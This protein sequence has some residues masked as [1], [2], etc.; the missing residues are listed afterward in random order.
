MKEIN[1]EEIDLYNK[2]EKE[3]EDAKVKIEETKYK[4]IQSVRNKYSDANIKSFCNIKELIRK[5]RIVS[6]LFDV[7][8]IYTFFFIFVLITSSFIMY[9]KNLSVSQLI[10]VG[11]IM[12]GIFLLITISLYIEKNIY[13]NKLNGVKD[14]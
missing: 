7:M 1:K 10:I 14:I 8:S 11:I 13:K 9:K 5:Y 12:L 2:Y 4:L 6:L 3:M